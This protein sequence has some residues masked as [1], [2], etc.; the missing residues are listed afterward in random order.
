MA[1]IDKLSKLVAV[2]DQ[3]HHSIALL[4]DI[5]AKRLI[6]NWNRVRPQ[7]VESSDF[8]RSVLAAGMEQGLRETPMLL[9]AMPTEVRKIAAQSLAAATFAHYP[10]FISK[11][12]ER[13]AKIKVRGAIRGDSEFYLVRDHIDLL[14]GELSS[15]LELRLLYELVD[16]FECN[17]K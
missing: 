17:G 1:C 15:E 10:D 11:D 6:E 9:R 2:N 13:I 12:A 4:D 5:T 3:F 14:E 8:P 16:K 7:Y